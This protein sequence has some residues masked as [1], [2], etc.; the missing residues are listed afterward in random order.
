M[1]EV[2]GFQ[3]FRFDSAL[4]GNL[5]GVITPPYDVISPEE[6]VALAAGNPHNMTH[7]ILPEGEGMAKYD[8][9]AALLEG[10]IASGA[11]K[12]DAEPSIYLLEQEFAF[13]DGVRRV[14]RGFFAA[15]RLP[16]PGEDIVLAHERTFGKVVDDRMNLMVA[17]RANLGPVFV[18]YD[19]PRGALDDILA[20]MD[21]RPPDMHATTIDG[22][23]QRLWR[24][25]QDNR[26]SEFLAGKRLYIADGHH[27]FRTA[28]Q[29][30][31]LMREREHPAGPRPYDSVLLG[32][33]AM[34][35]P[36]LLVGAT[37]RLMPIPDNFRLD[38]FLDAAKPWFLSEKVDADLTKSVNAAPGC[39]LGVAIHG[40][41][42]YLLT[43]R[44]LDRAQFLGDD[45]GPSWR[46]LDVAVLHRGLIER[47]M[48]LPDDAPLSYEKDPAKTLEAVA[49]GRFGM[50][51]IVKPTRVQQIRACAEAGEA[52]PHKSTYFFPKLPTGM[53]IK[54]LC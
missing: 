27:R 3:G 41:G 24:I 54:R 21:T 9:A 40:Q 18:L 48:G 44:D 26:V 45:H 33:V 36:G 47:V 7:V 49:E 43:L 1:L 13:L 5:D 34:S 15:A 35:D 14:R 28:C 12:E 52:M 31:D 38:A 10:W 23:H 2:S 4:T 29:Y 22:V 25:P 51:F 17:T 16:E 53:V 39:A 6:R 19:D 50:A 32:F 42:N 46:D 37:H 8:N 30:R 20:A 11:L